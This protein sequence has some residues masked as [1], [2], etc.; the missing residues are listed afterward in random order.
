MLISF[1][2]ELAANGRA[3]QIDKIFKSGGYRNLLV[4]ELSSYYETEEKFN[5]LFEMIPEDYQ[6]KLLVKLSVTKR[7]TRLIH[8]Y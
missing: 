4:N 2:K 8:T 5:E 1:L 6:N 7:V 3:S